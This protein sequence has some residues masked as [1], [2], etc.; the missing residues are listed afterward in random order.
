VEVD[1]FAGVDSCAVVDS[2]ACVDSVA[3]VDSEVVRGACAGGWSALDE[4]LVEELG[5]VEVVAPVRSPACPRALFTL[6][7]VA[8]PLLT[9]VLPGNA[10]AATSVRRPVTTTLLAIN[11]RLTRLSLCKA[12]S[13]VVVV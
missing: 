13:R 1:S 3:C 8:E 6:A 2:E 7:A 11:T 5:F 10:C 12:A 9:V 4:E